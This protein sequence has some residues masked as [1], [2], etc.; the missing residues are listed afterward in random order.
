MQR[1]Q[2]ATILTEGPTAAAQGYGS[3]LVPTVPGQVRTKTLWSLSRRAQ[4][5]GERASCFVTHS[6]SS[7]F[8]VGDF[9]ISFC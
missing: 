5:E 3:A 4:K 2:G 9:L 7:L 8:E 1:S 6:Q